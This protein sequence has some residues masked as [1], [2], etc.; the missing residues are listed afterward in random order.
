M[1]NRIVEIATDGVHLSAER[2]FLKVSKDR[3]LIGKIAIDDVAG[4]V[5]R[6]YGASFSANICAAFAARNAP[7]VICSSDQSPASVIWPVSGHYQQ[8][9]HMQAQAVAKK[10]LLK[11]LW[12]ELVTAKILAQASVLESSGKD[13][14]DLKSMAARI[15]SGDPDNIEAQAARRY[16]SRLMGD[17]FTRDRGEKGINAALNY[18]YT[19]LRAASARS[20][21]AAGLHPSL[22]IQHQSR[23]DALRLADDLMEPFRPFVDQ[24]VFKCASG[25]TEGVV[26][27]L[28]KETKAKLVEVLSR[29]LAGP[30]GLSPL[31]TCMD[32][33]AQSLVA[34]FTGERRSLE[35]PD[36]SAPTRNADQ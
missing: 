11:R 34:V 33:L 25:L 27:E 17:G 19:V 24:A 32:R 31:Q 30:Q 22:S 35:L 14:D 2:G 29:D 20:I 15:H 23:G 9:L 4:L 28:D 36:V 6:G 13:A 21:I 3:E 12:A 16:W 7:I 1:Q 10:P 26:L 8:G 18:G 5:V